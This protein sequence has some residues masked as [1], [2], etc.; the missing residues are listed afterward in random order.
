MMRLLVVRLGPLALVLLLVREDML[1]LL[2]GLVVWRCVGVVRVIGEWGT[3][4]G[5]E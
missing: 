4:P 5:D 1:H 3:L 2:L